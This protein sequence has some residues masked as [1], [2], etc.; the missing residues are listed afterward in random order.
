MRRAFS[1]SSNI[2]LLLSLNFL[3]KYVEYDKFEAM[4]TLTRLSTSPMFEEKCDK[5]DLYQFKIDTKIPDIPGTRLSLV[6]K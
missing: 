3:Y 6:P 4:S 2:L 5:R 1:L